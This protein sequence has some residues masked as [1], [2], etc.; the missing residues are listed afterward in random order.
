[1]GQSWDLEEELLADRLIL[2]P[3]QTDGGRYYEFSGN[4]TLTPLLAGAV[5]TG[6]MVTPAGSSRIWTPEF[7][8]VVTSR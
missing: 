2:T 1:V 8:G 3:S 5:I 6:N 7:Q 4:G